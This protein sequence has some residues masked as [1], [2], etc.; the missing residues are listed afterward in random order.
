MYGI[1]FLNL[2]TLA[3]WHLIKRSF[4]QPERPS[5]MES[6]VLSKDGTNMVHG[7]DKEDAQSLIDVLDEVGCTIYHVQNTEIYASA[8]NQLGAAGHA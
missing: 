4:T 8:S 3:V 1:P 6:V 2:D 5:L 7:L